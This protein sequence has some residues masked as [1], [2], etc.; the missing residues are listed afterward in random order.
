MARGIGAGSGRAAAAVTAAM[1][2]VFQELV[3]RN[4]FNDFAAF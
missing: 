4:C 2:S 3:R 1:V